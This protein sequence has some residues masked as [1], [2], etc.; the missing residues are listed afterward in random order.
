M[1]VLCQGCLRGRVVALSGIAVLAAVLGYA[2][3]HEELRSGP[4]RLL[5]ARGDGPGGTQP[6]AV[7]NATPLTMK[8]TSDQL[9]E[10]AGLRIRVPY[11]FLLTT[12][13]VK[14]LIMLFVVGPPSLRKTAVQEV[15]FF[16]A[17]IVP[18]LGT[19]VSDVRK[20]AFIC[21]SEGPSIWVKAN[22]AM[23]SLGAS[24]NVT[25]GLTLIALYTGTFSEAKWRVA[26]SSPAP[27]EP[28]TLGWKDDVDARVRDEASASFGPCVDPYMV[29]IVSVVLPGIIACM[30]TAPAVVAFGYMV[31]PAAL[32]FIGIVYMSEPILRRALVARLACCPGARRKGYT[33]LEPEKMEEC[34]RAWIAMGNSDE[35]F[36]TQRAF[37]EKTG[38]SFGA[39]SNYLWLPF[40]GALCAP[41]V[42][43]AARLYTGCGYWPALHDTWED[44]HFRNWL[45]FMLD[46]SVDNVGHL[47]RGL[48]AIQSGLELLQRWLVLISHLI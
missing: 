13:L 6:Q 46:S 3:F 21:L 12:L 37:Y 39:V 48:S 33:P 14:P 25:T 32:V 19:A 9:R 2:L 28:L 7:T 47:Q 8:S 24:A 42:P 36:D 44:R 18:M 22:A 40:L 23:I 30:L 10:L 35:D 4:V 11:Y 20:V 38:V 34:R 5:K 29:V 45:R 26:L 27:P 41:F 16:V 15:V 43:V 31:V 17:I 1:V